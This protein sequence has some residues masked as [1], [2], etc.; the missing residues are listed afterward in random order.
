MVH[1]IERFLAALLVLALLAPCAGALADSTATVTADSLTVYTTP[2]ADTAEIAGT[3][4]RGTQVTV[5]AVS[6]GLAKVVIKGDVYYV[7]ASKLSIASAQVAPS[8]PNA[9]ATP[10]PPQ[11]T[12]TTTT[13]DSSSGAVVSGQSATITASKLVIYKKAS[14]SSDTWGTAAMGVSVTVLATSGSWAAVQIAGKI[15]YCAYAGLSIYPGKTETAPAEPTVT[16]EPAQSD[17]TEYLVNGKGTCVA[18]DA[19]KMYKKPN[20]SDG[21]YGTF[22][23]GTSL[24][25]SAVS[26]QWAKITYKGKTGYVLRAGLRPA[27]AADGAS[28]ENVT[29]V[30]GYTHQTV[31]TTN[32]YQKPSTSSTVMK[33]V[34]TGT[35]L[36]VKATSGGWAKVSYSGVNCYA[37]E[38]SL[39]EIANTTSALVVVAQA[40][41]YAS[42]SLSA[43]VSGTVSEG[44]TI[45]VYGVSNGWAKVVYNNTRAYMQSAD[46]YIG[47]ASYSTIKS[48]DSGTNV[49][50]LQ[51]RLETLGY[52]DGVPAGNYGS[53]T[54]AAVKRFQQQKGLNVTGTANNATQAALYSKSAPES[55][56]LSRTLTSGSTGEYVTRL[57]TRLLYKNYYSNSVDGDYGTNTVAAVKAFQKNASLEETGTADSATL[58][59]LFAPGAPKGTTTRPA[60]S[61]G[62]PSLDAPDVVS[63]NED[64]ETV[65]QYALAQLGKPYVYGSA[66]PNSFDCSGLTYYCFKKVGITLPRTAYDVGYSAALGERI[67]YEDLKRG[68]IVCFNTISDSDLSD[69]VG[70]YLGDGKFIHAPHTG[71]DVIVASMS[72]GYYARNFSWGRRVIK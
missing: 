1:R 3:I 64:I 27:T 71:S 19:L 16:Q 26:G 65:I 6:N 37:L 2:Y 52:F 28:S 51:T 18:L 12:G 60:G 9:T 44:T 59:A 4:R 7:D 62:T 31:T 25:V 54:T 57:Q 55:D 41:M 14:K 72:S 61:N 22:K 66:G 35:K 39:V 49:Q 56:L 34:S 43:T 53:I 47:T 32:L 17:D 36:T 68:D 20:T 10:A 8:N 33:T 15:G 58:R 63:D 5:R 42:A 24:E 23:A 40:K 30:T 38:S 70:I 13:T 67:A 45:N 29:S 69:H 46:L 50:A 48:G 11:T 21:Y